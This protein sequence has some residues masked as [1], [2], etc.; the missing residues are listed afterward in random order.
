MMVFAMAPILVFG[1][2]FKVGDTYNLDSGTTINENLYVAAGTVGISGTVNGDVLAT[3]GSVIVSGPV[4]GD[5]EV[6]GGNINISSNVT[7]D[8]RVAGGNIMVSK[9]AGGDLVVAGGQVNV[10]SGSRFSKDVRIVGGSVTFLGS[11]GKDLNI[12]AGDVYVD[13]PVAGNLKVT[14]ENIKLGPNASVVGN[15]DYSSQKIAVLEQG[16]VVGG[17][18]NFNKINLTVKGEE[19]S[20]GLILGFMSIAFAFKTIM[21]I[22]VGL[23]MIYFFGRQTK[24][25]LD[26]GVPNFWKEALRG[27]IILI[28]LPVAIILSFATIIG[29]FLGLITLFFYIALCILASV[30]SVLIFAGLAL[31]HLFKK[32]NYEVN[33][34][35][36]VISALVFGLVSF[37]PFVGWIFAFIIFLSSLGSVSTVLYNKIRL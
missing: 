26:R 27:F 12:K 33:W 21:L 11:A 22:V 14:A 28:L 15:F 29:T 36:L 37:I 10:L 19:A 34:W 25:V 17:T 31:K 1:A 3:G 6:A 32:E 9:S 23:V 35:I 18:T 13:G 4:S 8:I 16:A 24:S 7:G 2:T 5:V 30:F 20:K